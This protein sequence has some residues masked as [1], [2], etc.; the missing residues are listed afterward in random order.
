LLDA[1]AQSVWAEQNAWAFVPRPTNVGS[2]S[3]PFIPVLERSAVEL[4]RANITLIDIED[5]LTIKVA[6]YSGAVS[7]RP[8]GGVPDPMVEFQWA[9]ALPAGTD[10]ATTIRETIPSTT[11]ALKKCAVKY[12]NPADYAGWTDA[13][14]SEHMATLANP[15]VQRNF[16]DFR[17]PDPGCWPLSS[18]VSFVAKTT[19]SS[20]V[21]ASVRDSPPAGK[22][23]RSSRCS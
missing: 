4:N 12:T 21:S 22:E 5:R 9:A 18:L 14:R 10:P 6:T 8:I 19:Y 11:D 3:N 1:M 13:Q 17:H 7:Y 16:I 2:D 15:G 20:A 23:C